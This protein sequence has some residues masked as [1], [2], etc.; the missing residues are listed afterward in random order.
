[1]PEFPDGSVSLVWQVQHCTG[2]FPLF[3]GCSAY[4]SPVGM[5]DSSSLVSILRL[6]IG[7]VAPHFYIAVLPV[8]QSIHPSN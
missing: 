4:Q 1:M 5:E 6:C 2:Y 8:S 7:A 3:S